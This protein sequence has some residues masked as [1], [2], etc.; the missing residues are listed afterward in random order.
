MKDIAFLS[1]PS[2][3]LP[4]SAD[5]NDIE[6]KDGEV[7]TVEGRQRMFQ[8]IA[9]ILLTR[10]GA[11]AIFPTYGSEIPNLIGQRNIDV[12]SQI[13]DS[14]VEALAF[15]TQVETSTEKDENIKS[16][17]S[18]SVETIS[19]DP[20]Q[21]LVRLTVTLTDGSVVQTNVKV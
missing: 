14:V 21:K 8:D 3:T 19:G 10:I 5:A 15:L 6:F 2:P 20:R 1:S 17:K 11:D 13:S 7:V 4:L 12:D 18:L 9:K 16:I